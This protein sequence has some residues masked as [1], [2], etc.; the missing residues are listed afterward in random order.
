MAQETLDHV[1]SIL[2]VLKYLESV[3][4]DNGISSQQPRWAL[5]CVSMFN[6]CLV[7]FRAS[8]IEFYEKSCNRAYILDIGL[9]QLFAIQLEAISAAQLWI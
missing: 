4:D 6:I 9:Y 8:S 7:Y 1:K 2:N 5:V 3:Y